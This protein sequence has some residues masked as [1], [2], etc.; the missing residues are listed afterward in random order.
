M[1]LGEIEELKVRAAHL[2]E[3]G[4]HATEPIESVTKRLVAVQQQ[5]NRARA[6]LEDLREHQVQ[7]ELPTASEL[8]KSLDDLCAEL[9]QGDRQ[10][11]SFDLLF[12]G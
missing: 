9:M 8:A 11:K 3:I 5:L 7:L 12:R 2:T 6:K 1:I 4:E 10:V